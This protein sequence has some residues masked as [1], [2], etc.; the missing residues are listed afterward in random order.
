MELLEKSLEHIKNGLPKY[1]HNHIDKLRDDIDKYK[2]IE[3]DDCI[4]V[5]DVDGVVLFK[6]YTQMDLY[7]FSRENTLLKLYIISYF[8]DNSNSAKDVISNLFYKETLTHII[9]K[10]NLDFRKKFT[11]SYVDKI[12]DDGGMK[13]RVKYCCVIFLIPF[14]IMFDRILSNHSIVY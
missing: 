9:D 2:I 1:I 5:C 6:S 3:R 11:S 12:D 13:I 8:Y 14:G 10:Y 7:K 4:R